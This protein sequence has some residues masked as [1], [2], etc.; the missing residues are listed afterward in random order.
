M[1]KISIIIPVH[2]E[3]KY[4]EECLKSIINQTMDFKD[5]EVIM[6]DDASVDNSYAIM[7]DY[8][9]IYENFIAL[10]RTEKSGSAGLKILENFGG[11]IK[12]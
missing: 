7:Q 9:N 5:L 12:W 11:L 3:E 1:Y 8:S 6:I 10:R 4:L 2:N